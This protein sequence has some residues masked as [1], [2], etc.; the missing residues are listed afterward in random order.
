[1]LHKYL[2]AIGFSKLNSRKELQSL[3][4]ECIEKADAK[5][6]VSIDDETIFAEFNKEFSKGMGIAVRGEF[7][8][9]NRFTY[10]YYFPYVIGTNLSSTE[11]ISIERHAEKES[12]AGVCDDVRVGVSLIFYLQN[13]I[14]YIKLKNAKKLP[15]RGTSLT[16]SALSTQGIIMMPIEKDA[17]AQ[18]KN[19]QNKINRLKLLQEAKRGNEE[20]METLSLDDMDTYSFVAKKIHKQDLFSLVDTCF[21]PYGVE[22]D[23][24]SIVGQIIACRQQENS[25]TKEIVHILSVE[26]NDLVFDVCINSVDLYGEPAVGRRFKGSIWLQGFVN[27]PMEV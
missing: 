5:S 21:M 22:C 15:I 27:F 19:N 25:M 14:P 7:D 13:I 6:Y 23:M 18:K 17:L 1:M 16:L 12:Y 2:R 20:A 26:C 4:R 8:E 24:Y 11:D 10:E 3:L 9:E